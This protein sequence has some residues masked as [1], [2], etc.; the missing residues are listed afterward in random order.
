MLSKSFFSWTNS[1]SNNINNC[2]KIT[3]IV[4]NRKR[5]ARDVI[6]NIVN[7]IGQVLEQFLQQIQSKSK[8]WSRMITVDGRVIGAPMCVQQQVDQQRIES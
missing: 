4:R 2:T 8:Q 1:L 5:A 6:Q 3:G 7:Y